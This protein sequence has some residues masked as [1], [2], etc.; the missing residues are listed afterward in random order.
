MAIGIYIDLRLTHNGV[1][2]GLAPR[3]GSSFAIQFKA[4]TAVHAA[5]F[6]HCYQIGNDAS[7]D[8]RFLSARHLFILAATN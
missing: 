3:G 6:C 5:T 8:L 7:C 4:E 1:V 2:S